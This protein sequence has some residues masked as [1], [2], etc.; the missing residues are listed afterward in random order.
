MYLLR[1]ILDPDIPCTA[2][3]APDVLLNYLLGSVGDPDGQWCEV[4]LVGAPL[5]AGFYAIPFSSHFSLSLLSSLSSL[6]ATVVTDGTLQTA[7]LNENNFPT[8]RPNCYAA[9]AARQDLLASLSVT[10]RG[11]ADF[12]G[13]WLVLAAGVGL[14]VLI[15]LVEQYKARMMVSCHHPPQ[16][17]KLGGFGATSRRF[18]RGVMLAMGAAEAE[19]EDGTGTPKRPNITTEDAVTALST[20]IRAQHKQTHTVRTLHKVQLEH[21]HGLIVNTLQHGGVMGDD[22]NLATLR[23]QDGAVEAMAAAAAAAVE[24]PDSSEDEDGI[25]PSHAVNY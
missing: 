17:N 12:A 1:A 10:S 19:D 18:A 9:L 4:E 2:G 25:G 13:I 15:K 20:L 6:A 22:W 23:H 21:A 3:V 16:A 8:S 24:G 11:L 7:N 5:S 14:G